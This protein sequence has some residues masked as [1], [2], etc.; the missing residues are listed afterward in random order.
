MNGACQPLEYLKALLL[1]HTGIALSEDQ[2]YLANSKLGSMARA[3]GHSG[4]HSFLDA[5]QARPDPATVLQVIDA[6]TTHETTFFRDV[7]VFTS[8]RDQVF[9]R[10]LDRIRGERALRVWSAG[11]ATGQEA[12][13][14]AMLLTE[15]CRARPGSSFRILASDVSLGV[16]EQARE[17]R[18]SAL[19]IRRGLGEAAKRQYFT[20]VQGSYRVTESLRRSIDWQR[21]S[22][23][24]CWPPLPS[25]DL[26][27]MRN[28]LI[29]FD[30]ATR[31]RILEYASAKLATG[32]HLVL[33]TSETAFGSC[34]RLVPEQVG[35]VTFYRSE[36]DPRPS[37]GTSLGPPVQ[38]STKPPSV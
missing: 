38:L 11:C 17:G 19:E 27:L 30:P 7:D 31:S 15:L 25:F 5:L 4:I 12:Y 10:L 3:R 35:G 28:V 8:L 2:V 18:Y 32:G 6:M 24:S 36:H 21:F 1:A 16:I 14:V 33:G 26:I 23:T 22:L 20:E 9:P 29:Y 37:A 13:S 34:R